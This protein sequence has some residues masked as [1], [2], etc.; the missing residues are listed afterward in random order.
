LANGSEYEG[1]YVMGKPHGRGKFTWTNGE[2]YDGDWNMGVK[3]GE[4]NL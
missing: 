2:F 4:G 1:Y 3:E